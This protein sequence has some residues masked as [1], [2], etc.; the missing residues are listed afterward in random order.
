MDGFAFGQPQDVVLFNSTISHNLRYG[1]I[2][3]AADVCTASGSALP[4]LAMSSRSRVSSL[5]PQFYAF[6]SAAELSGLLKRFV[7]CLDLAWQATSADIEKAAKS[8]QLDGFIDQQAQG[9]EAWH[10]VNAVGTGVSL[11]ERYSEA[12]PILCPDLPGT[13]CVCVW[14]SCH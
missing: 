14:Q 2:D 6:A 4:L 8:A 13:M 12:V 9:Y 3:Q 5:C 7:M 1:N 10:A 11:F